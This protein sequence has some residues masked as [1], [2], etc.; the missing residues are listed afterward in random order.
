MDDPYNPSPIGNP[1]VLARRNWW[2]TRLVILIGKLT[3]KCP[4]VTR[5]LSQSMDH[6]LALRTRLAIRVH[7]LICCWCQ[8]YAEQLHAIRRFA[9]AYDEH[10]PLVCS[11]CLSQ[12][13]R[14]R[15]KRVL[16]A[17]LRK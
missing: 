16:D 13:A 14:E 6:R 12:Q 10:A 15:L 7:Y 4:E 5:L 8:R 3:P 2:Q 11:D 9:R 1:S 17:E